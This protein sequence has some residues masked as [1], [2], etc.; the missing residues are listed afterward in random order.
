MFIASFNDLLK[1]SK[2]KELEFDKDDNKS[3]TFVTAAANLRATIFSIAPKS[4]FDIK[5]DAGNIIPAIA[6]TNA[7]V[8][9]LIVLEAYKILQNQFNNCKTTYIRR[10]P[11]GKALYLNES[12]VAP[13]K[14]CYVCSCG[15]I[16]VVLNTKLMTLQQFIQL[17]LKAELNLIDPSLL[18][19]DSIIYESDAEMEGQLVK[20]LYDVHVQHDAII[21]ITDNKQDFS[22]KITVLHSDVKVED[23]QLIG[24][25]KT[26]Q[27]TPITNGAVT[28]TSAVAPMELDTK[29]TDQNNVSRKRKAAEI[30]NNADDKE[31]SAK[32]Q[33][34]IDVGDAITID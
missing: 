20:K 14:N 15:F 11:A 26:I 1:R 17:I 3:L 32:K 24:N 7:I 23:Y 6:T 2:A 30:T 21:A 13:N 28:T 25:V 9:G 18:V 5:A 27:P 10:V 16:S 19:G 34:A 4:R 12:L 22:I 33:K 29:Q 8:A 31:K